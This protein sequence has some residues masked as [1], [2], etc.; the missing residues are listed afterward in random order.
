M[1][2]RNPIGRMS[3]GRGVALIDKGIL[4][5]GLGDHER[6]LTSFDKA[7]SICRPISEK[8][9]PVA[10]I[11]AQALDNKAR[12]LIDLGRSGEAVPCFEEAIQVHEG[13]VR[14]E[15]TQ[16][17]VREIATSVR[18][19]SHPRLLIADIGESP[20]PRVDKPRTLAQNQCLRTNTDTGSN[21]SVA[22]EKIRA[23]L[24]AIRKRR[25]NP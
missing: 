3:R 25:V 19:V 12:S 5:T 14:G 18:I 10:L 1:L 22:T 15:G 13:I 6:A 9:D 20:S 2:M 11:L 8:F 7:V 21:L 24:A 4:L 16:Q 17:D 23:R